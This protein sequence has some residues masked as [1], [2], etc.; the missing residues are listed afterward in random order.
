MDK[1]TAD[2]LRSMTRRVTLKN[3]RDDGETQRASVEVAEGIW[4]DDV[5]ILQPAGFAGAPVEDGA[6]AVAVAIGGDEGDLVVLPP[7][8]PSK[9]MGQMPQ[10]A[11]G[12]Y[13]SAGDKLVINPDG[14]AVLHVA[15]ALRVEAQTILLKAGGVTV[16]IGAG[17]V[18]IEGGT[19]THNGKNIGDTHVHTNVEPGGGL[20]G[21][22]Q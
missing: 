13:S 12:I 1:D 9:R 7:S 21:A 4:R 5:E 8:N 18:A 10:G 3:V 2:R 15:G 17:G 16:T 22:P 11:A 19:V 6:V 14:T 20:S